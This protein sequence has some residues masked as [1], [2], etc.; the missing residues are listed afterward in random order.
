M[1][2]FSPIKE[3]SLYMRSYNIFH[4]YFSNLA[5]IVFEPGALL[6]VCISTSRLDFIPYSMVCYLLYAQIVF[7]C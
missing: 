4:P 5:V 7:M 1:T 3:I 2:L 6:I